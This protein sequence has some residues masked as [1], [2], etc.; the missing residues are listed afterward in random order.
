MGLSVYILLCNDGT[1]YTGLSSDVERRFAEHISGKYIDSYTSKRLPV[2]LVWS[3]QFQ[4]NLEAISWEKRIKKWSKKKKEALI[5]GDFNALCELSECKNE[6]HYKN[7][8]ID[9]W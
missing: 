2:Q 4:S 8:I 5:R 3:N 7:R 6:T 1:Y 9:K